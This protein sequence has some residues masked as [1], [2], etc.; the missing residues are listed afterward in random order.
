MN[1]RISVAGEDFGSNLICSGYLVED[2]KILLV[3]H[4]RFD[5]WVPPG[6]HIEAGETFGQTAE[7]EFLEETGIAVNAISAAPVI[8]PEDENATPLPL[9]FYTDLEVEGFPVPALV[10]FFFVRRAAGDHAPIRPQESEVLD[11]RF[12]SAE[13]LDDL[14][15]FDQVRSLARYALENHPDAKR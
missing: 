5:K 7:R 14:A 12:F 2:G 4:N 11:A 1:S 3:H 15:T 8:H 6:G 10:Q 13:E 9:P